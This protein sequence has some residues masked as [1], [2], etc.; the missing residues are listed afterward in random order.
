MD[1]TWWRPDGTV[2]RSLDP[3]RAAEPDTPGACGHRRT[4]SLP[5]PGARLAV[6]RMFF[7]RPPARE[8]SSNAAAR[9]CRRARPPVRRSVRTPSAVS[10]AER[11]RDAA[12]AA[13]DVGR[14]QPRLGATAG[15]GR[16]SAGVARPGRQFAVTFLGFLVRRSPAPIW[17]SVGVMALSLVDVARCPPMDSSDVTTGVKWG[18]CRPTGRPDVGRGVR[19]RYRR[20]SFVPT[21]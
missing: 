8:H 11:E 6:Q 3:G 14:S 9:W 21:R 18:S 13:P 4:W 16:D 5:R 12:P 7:H 10:G 17:L 15:A 1:Q 2:L 19:A 20:K